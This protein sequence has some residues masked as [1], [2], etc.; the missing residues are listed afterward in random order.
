MDTRSHGTSVA[1]IIGTQEGV[2][3]TVG[4]NWKVRI[5]PIRIT[6]LRNG[7]SSRGSFIR[8]ARYVAGMARDPSN[9]I[10]VMNLS[11]GGSVTESTLGPNLAATLCKLPWR[12]QLASSP[13][14]LRS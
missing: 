14:V 12:F 11:M 2:G 5:L 6:L 13:V 8:A 4:M 3:E 1:G 7:D 10:R 9:H